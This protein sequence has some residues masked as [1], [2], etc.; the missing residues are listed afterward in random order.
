MLSNDRA[1]LNFQVSHVKLR[2]RLRDGILAIGQVSAV[3]P[4]ASQQNTLLHS[5]A[6]GFFLNVLLSLSAI[7]AIGLGASSQISVL[8]LLLLASALK[9]EL[10]APAFLTERQELSLLLLQDSWR[11]FRLLVH[12]VCQSD[13]GHACLHSAHTGLGFLW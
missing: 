7:F 6:N 13:A 12:Y 5:Y 11:P 8:Q 3:V 9:A 10:Q 4:A 1:L 2:T